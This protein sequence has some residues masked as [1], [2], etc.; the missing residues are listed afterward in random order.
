M[1]NNHIKVHGKDNGRRLLSWH[2]FFFQNVIRMG[3]GDS[4]VFCYGWEKFV[5]KVKGETESGVCGVCGV[6]GWDKCTELRCDS[7]AGA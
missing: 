6:C 4:W 2:G 1:Y 7:V 3:L 5:P